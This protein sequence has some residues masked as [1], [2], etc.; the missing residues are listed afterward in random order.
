VFVAS[1]DLGKWPVALRDINLATGMVCRQSPGT[2]RF[3][4]LAEAMSFEP[5]DFYDLVHYTPGGARKIG[6]FLAREL[7]FIG[8]P[9]EHGNRE[10]E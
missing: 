3:V 6:E 9:S 5:A 8:L 4:D 2:C 10:V 7:G 1:P